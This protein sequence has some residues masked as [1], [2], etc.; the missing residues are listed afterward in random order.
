METVEFGINTTLITFKLEI[1]LDEATLLVFVPSFTATQAITRFKCLLWHYIDPV[2]VS[3]VADSGI[4]VLT[5]LTSPEYAG[6]HGACRITEEVGISC[7]QYV[8]IA[9]THTHTHTHSLSHTCRHIFINCPRVLFIPI[10]HFQIRPHDGRW[11]KDN[12]GRLNLF[13]ILCMWQHGRWNFRAPRPY[14]TAQAQCHECSWASICS[15]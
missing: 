11:T 13:H 8:C 3:C 5:V 4:A 10:H 7:V 6:L 1:S 15:R 9:H 2:D 12:S 14:G